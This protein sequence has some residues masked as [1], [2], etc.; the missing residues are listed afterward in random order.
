MLSFPF[1]VLVKMNTKYYPYKLYIKRNVPDNIFDIP[2]SELWNLCSWILFI[3]HISIG[4]THSLS[5]SQAFTHT[6]ILPFS[7]SLLVS[8][9]VV[10]EITIYHNVE[11]TKL[12]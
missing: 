9:F 4:T 7:Y 10:Y 6:I 12:V 5:L 2:S 3:S 11:F 8:L 1:F